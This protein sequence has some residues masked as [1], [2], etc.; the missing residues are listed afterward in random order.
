MNVAKQTLGAVTAMS[1]VV[2]AA[3]ITRGSSPLCDM[4]GY[5]A[6]AGLTASI[7][8]DALAVTWSG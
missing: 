6:S 1:L 3:N 2:A 4:S 5:H 8:G 7:E